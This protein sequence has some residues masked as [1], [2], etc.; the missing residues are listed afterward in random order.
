VLLD[1]D[2]YPK[3]GERY[4][5]FSFFETIPSSPSDKGQLA[6]AQPASDFGG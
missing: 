6:T 5:A 1:F 3:S 2:F 4:G